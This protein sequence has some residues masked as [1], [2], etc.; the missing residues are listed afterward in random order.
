[1]RKYVKRI[2]A[3]FQFLFYPKIIKLVYRS[4]LSLLEP[5][6]LYELY[7][8]VENIENKN[9]KGQIIEAGCALGGS[10]IVI[11]KAKKN[12]RPFYIYD[13]FDMIPSPSEK[14]GVDAHKRYE[15][16]KSG[17]AKGINE[18]PYYGYEQNLLDK[19]KNSFNHCNID[20]HQENINFI[21]GLYQDTLKVNGKV[22][23]AHID[24]DWYDSVMVCLEQIVPNLVSGAVLI[25]DD[26]KDW[27]GCKSAVD[28]YFQ[29]KHDDYIFVQKSRLHI[30]RR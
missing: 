18:K 21:K 5:L 16:I 22:A 30:I 14:D 8:S 3:K 15:I 23:F 7:K 10:A 4:Q 28:T 29:N 17:K 13:V 24:A 9:I 2:Y 12:T 20:L 26:Y 27:V 1:V 6:A 25:I 19:V 11:A